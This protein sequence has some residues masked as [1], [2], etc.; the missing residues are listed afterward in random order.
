MKG[1]CII[2]YQSSV[3]LGQGKSGG[4]RGWPYPDAR[5]TKQGLK[6]PYNPEQP[7]RLWETLDF[8]DRD[9]DG[10]R[11]QPD[12]TGLNW[13]IIVQFNQPLYAHASV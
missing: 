13:K 2:K 10:Y 7:K 12:G 11:K 6:Q 5:W 9:G 4:K 1:G 8:T 3:M